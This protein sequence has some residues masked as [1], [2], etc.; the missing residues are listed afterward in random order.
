MTYGPRDFR[1]PSCQ[2]IYHGLE[3][4]CPECGWSPSAKPVPSTSLGDVVVSM[5]GPG[6]YESEK[7][8]EYKD[9]GYP[10]EDVPPGGIK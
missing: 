2:T 8:M 9:G 7:P 4:L 3:M 10:L 5:G 6:T 1:C